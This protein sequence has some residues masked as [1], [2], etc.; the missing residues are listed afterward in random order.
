M[1]VQSIDLSHPLDP[2]NMSFYPSDPPYSCPS[3]AAVPEHG[4]SVQAL[5]L[6]TH[7]GTHVDAPS[8]FFAQA[9]SIDQIPLASFIRPAI[10]IDVSQK[11]IPRARI[12]WDDHN[13]SIDDRSDTIILICTDWCKHWGKPEYVNHPFLD[14]DATRQLVARG[15]SNRKGPRMILVCTRRFLV[16]A[17]SSWRT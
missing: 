11:V 4:Y 13:L 15:I 14:V 9:E 3:H 2:S 6:Y 8:H 5:S 10:V 12:T 16:L 7:T 1:T 17:D